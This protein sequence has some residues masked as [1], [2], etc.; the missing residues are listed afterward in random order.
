MPSLPRIISAV[1]YVVEPPGLWTDRMQWRMGDRVPHVE[2][3]RNGTDRW[4]IDGKVQPNVGRGAFPSAPFAV[5]ATRHDVP[6]GV[7]EPLDRLEAMDR[8]GVSAQVLYPSAAGRGGE[9]LGAIADPDLQAA[10]VRVYN[11]WLLETWAGASDR[12]VPQCLVPISTAEAAADEAQRAI[13]HGHRGIIMPAAPWHLNPESP[14]TH[15]P[16]WDALW[17]IAESNAVP[18]CFHAG[19][20]ADILLPL[21]DGLSSPTDAVVDVIR[22]PISSAQVLFNFLLSGITDRFPGLKAVFAG[23]TAAWAPSNL[24][25][26][27]HQARKAMLE[28]DGMTVYPSEVFHRS[29]YVT[30]SYD[31]IGLRMLSAIGAENVLWCS[32]FPSEMSTW[33]DSSKVISENFKDVPVDDRDRVIGGNGAELYKIS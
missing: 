8:D 21:Y 22:G 26:A 28:R 14:H 18:V 12:F 33:P 29:C 16:K 20:D 32:A 2:R 24:E 25:H 19:S 15:D 17:N 4:V 10:C 9:T 30:T 6:G 3:L 11:D 7:S 5:P 1:D 27:D 31:N 13:S 23:T